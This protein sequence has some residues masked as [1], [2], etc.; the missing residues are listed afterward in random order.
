[1]VGVNLRVGCV[2]FSFDGCVI[3]EGWYEGV[4][5]FYVEVVVLVEVGLVA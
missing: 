4:G 3:V 1:L 5:I 2:L